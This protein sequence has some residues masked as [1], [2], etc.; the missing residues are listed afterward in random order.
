MCTGNP[1]SVRFGQTEAASVF[2]SVC[3]AEKTEAA[4]PRP[5]YIFTSIEAPSPREVVGGGEMLCARQRPFVFLLIILLSVASIILATLQLAVVSELANTTVMTDVRAPAS[6]AAA[7]ISKNSMV[8]TSYGSEFGFFNSQNSPSGFITASAISE[9]DQTRP[10]HSLTSSGTHFRN[11]FSLPDGMQQSRAQVQVTLKEIGHKQ[12]S[13]GNCSLLVFG[14]GNDSPF[15]EKWNAGGTTIFLEDNLK[16][17]RLISKRYPSLKIHLVKYWTSVKRDM[18][19]F[20]EASSWP[21]LKLDLPREVE[22]QEW[23]IILVDAP[24]GYDAQHPGR[25]QSM[26]TAALL[27]RPVG[28]LTIVDDCQRP[29]EKEYSRLFFGDAAVTFS[30]ARPNKIYHKIVQCYFRGGGERVK[31]TSSERIQ[32]NESSLSTSSNEQ[33]GGVRGQHKKDRRKSPLMSIHVQLHTVPRTRRVIFFVHVGH[34]RLSAIDCCAVLSAARHNPDTDIVVYMENVTSSWPDRRRCWGD[35]ANV[36]G[37]EF[38]LKD[39][40]S[41]TPLS[42]WYKQ[43]LSGKFG[44]GNTRQNIANAARLAFLYKKG[45]LYL[46]MDIITMANYASLPV[47][48][49]GAQGWDYL[50]TQHNTC[51]LNNAAMSFEPK[52]PFL[53]AYM[54]EF[55]DK[56]RNK[57]WGWNGPARISDTCRKFRCNNATDVIWSRNLTTYSV[58]AGFQAVRD[59]TFAPVHWSRAKQ[60]F[61]KKVTS[62]EWIRTVRLWNQLPGDY[63]SR[64]VFAVHIFNRAAGATKLTHA[65]KPTWHNG[66]HMTRLDH[67]LVQ[68]CGAQWRASEGVKTG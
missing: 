68:E 35:K 39:L 22:D 32:F 45:G 26:Y 23:D 46:D 65:T 12:Q 53:L 9:K 36:K 41:G 8:T 51:N 61:G 38:T 66:T 40:F 11:N 6:A 63:A 19:I 37:S 58:C 49:A 42:V 30:I 50:S 52:H 54:H 60:V 15:W 27:K 43:L 44:A 33:K 28:A 2:V 4:A 13:K 16:W 20:R 34:A 31:A 24:M 3:P 59:E 48:I 21:K 17:F 25:F 7:A 64:R 18:A 1:I 47:N 55:I 10:I 14:V 67:L 57:I 5:K 62:D 29:V 56:F